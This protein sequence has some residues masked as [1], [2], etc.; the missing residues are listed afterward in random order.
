MLRRLTSIALLAATAFSAGA[1]ASADPVIEP[2]AHPYK[3]VLLPVEGAD[4]AL[5]PRAGDGTDPEAGE[6]PF[7]MSADAL[8]MAIRDGILNA[9]VFSEIVVADSGSLAVDE[10]TDSVAAAAPIARRE[11]ADLILRVTV[12]TARL[13]DLGPNGSKYWSSLVW[14]MVPAPIWYI[15]DRTY[16]TSLV[17]NAELYDP[18]DPIKPTAS[19]VASSGEQELD[20]WDRGV[21]YQIS[22]TP[23]PWLAG[24]LVQVSQELT[25]RAVFQLMQ[26][27]VGELRTREIPSRF[28]VALG[29]DAGALT[30]EVQSRR[31]LRSLEVRSGDT[32][33]RAWAERQTGTLIDQSVSRPELRVYKARVAIPAGTTGLIRVIASDEGG[34]REV[35]SLRTDDQ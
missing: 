5:A 17:V 4:A 26:Q 31:R 22:F 28:D 25:E 9:R 19:V 24:D 21:D 30:I 12:S 33:L 34:G 10:F 13:R 23:P 7:A 11:R 18:S 3:V 6:V 29:W 15:G 8:R 16:E 32:V 20:M 2:L 1:C 14:F 35:R 27:L